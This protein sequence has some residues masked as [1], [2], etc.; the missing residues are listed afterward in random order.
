MTEGSEGR[1]T[2]GVG[3]G[4]GRRTG[5]LSTRALSSRSRSVHFLLEARHDP[6]GVQRMR[7]GLGADWE[8]ALV[9]VNLECGLSSW[10]SSTQPG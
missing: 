3:Q 7:W 9:L 10:A 4:E 2:K 6:G 8:A 1:T 5:S